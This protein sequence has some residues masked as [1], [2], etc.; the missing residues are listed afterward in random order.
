MTNTGTKAEALQSLFVYARD[1]NTGK[2]TRL[3]VPADLQVGMPGTPAELHL[4]GR[5]SINGTQFIT[6]AANK[7]VFTASVHDTVI[8]VSTVVNPVTGR[9]S[10]YLPP[11]PRD[12]ELHFIKDVSKT[13]GGIPIDLFPSPGAL[14][15]GQSLLTIN[16]DGGSLAIVWLAGGWHSLLTGSSGG[17]GGGGASV[18]ASYATISAEPGLPN[19]RQLA[20]GSH[21]SLTDGGAGGSLVIACTL[22][23]SLAVDSS[24][25]LVVQATALNFTN[26]L[27]ASAGGTQANVT[28]DTNIV[29]VWSGGTF[30][31]NAIFS[32]GLS[33]SLTRLADGVTPYLIAGPN[34]T[35]VTNSLGQVIVSGSTGGQI[36]V[37]NQGVPL[38][39]GPFST[40]NFTGPG[41]STTNVGGV[42]TVNVA[43]GS[44]FGIAP[45]YSLANYMMATSSSPFTVSGAGFNGVTGASGSLT[46][47]GGP[48]LIM[49]NAS[50]FASTAGA[51]SALTIKRNTTNLGDANYGIATVGPKAL[52]WQSAASLF[53]VDFVP[54]GTYTYTY[55][56]AALTG[57]AL[58]NP[59]GNTGPTAIMA[60]ELRNANVVTSSTTTS[61]LINGAYAAITGLSAS[62][63]PVKNPVLVMA[64]VDPTATVAGDWTGVDIFSGSTEFGSTTQGLQTMQ[65]NSA[66]EAMPGILL[67]LHQAPTF[68]ASN[69]YTVKARLGTGTGETFG[70][71][72]A[73]QQLMLWE[74][75]D[76]NW[77][78]FQTTAATSLGSGYT[79]VV[80]AVPS[81][82]LVSRGRPILA[83]ANI[84]NNPN[85]TGRGAYSL[86]KNGSSLG[87]SKGMQLADAENLNSA[88]AAATL[89]WIDP[90]TP[91]TWTYQVAGYN[92][93]GSNTA[94]ESSEPTSIFLYELD[95][96][97]QQGAIFSGWL[98]AGNRLMTTSSVSIDSP[99]RYQGLGVGSDAYLWVSGTVGLTGAA[100]RR[101]AFGGDVFT[102]GSLTAING[103]TGSV[104][105]LPTGLAF[106]VGQ[107]N[108]TITTN[109]LGQVVFS[110]AFSTGSL[111]TGSNTSPGGDF[112]QVAFIEN[113][114]P[115]E[116]WSQAYEVIVGGAFPVTRSWYVD[117]GFTKL[118]QRKTITRNSQYLPT[119][120]MWQLYA[121]D[122]TTVIRTFTDT[123]TYTGVFE[124]SRTRIQS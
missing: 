45:G 123:I 60:T 95:A 58:I 108:V 28:V 30:T 65:Q 61:T 6:S 17:G 54:A 77:K 87:A 113:V 34:I 25:S 67:Y 115:Y 102:S 91:G 72:N 20:A 37:E 90:V 23:S 69:T 112:R 100:A 81:P 39:G 51:A 42:A 104:T 94:G 24:G 47:N 53:Y 63:I 18:S 97:Y 86:L 40:F 116:G 121:V 2:I 66:G 74:L 49:V 44:T 75:T 8:A 117:A 21:I 84:N 31:G 62:I 105:Q 99:G 79:D 32:Q 55:A 50:W 14:I 16:D 10:V 124:A 4:T 85:S 92:V 5:L 70:K 88:N 73:L 78:Y 27:K 19:S 33:G 1:R 52:G 15:D 106:M 107:G 96:G 64:F 22:T 76:I 12:G 46:T 35:I 80:G 26:G 48:V 114:G 83:L 43:S 82:A 13:S 59:E 9:V 41:V 111:S 36:T 56:V 109:S 98:D 7:G 71:N 122:G 119:Q 57:T 3:A 101:A 38:S 11:S 120:E 89:M 110:G 118:I 103:M 29:A 68:N 93:S